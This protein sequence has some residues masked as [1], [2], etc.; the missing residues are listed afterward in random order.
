M[1]TSILFITALLGGCASL[2]DPASTPLSTGGGGMSAATAGATGAAG[3][4]SNPPTTFG[5]NSNQGGSVGVT[6]GGAAGNGSGGSSGAAGAGGTGAATAGSAGQASGG[7]SGCGIASGTEL[8]EDFESGALDAAK[9]K[10]VKPTVSASVMVDDTRPHRGKYALH[11]TVMPGQ[12]ST[13]QIADAVTFPAAS[14]AF[15]TRAYFYFSPDL[16]ADNMGGYHMAFLLATGNN[17]LGFVEAGL[18]SVGNKQYLGYSEY[19]GAGPDVH[20]HG[21]TFTEFGGS[22]KVQVVPMKWICLELFQGGDATTT[23]RRVWVDG[24]ELPEQKSLYSGRKPPTFSRM[25]IGV[26]QYHATPILNDVWVDDIRVSKDPIGC[27]K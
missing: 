9:W 10:S 7:S 13:A 4:I 17:D 24:M 27:D 25:S 19:Y 6:L 26:L 11:I 22:S 2:D 14:N 1:R 5:G 15:Y 8:C 21:P 3:T 18:A 12:S 20:Q 16:P 23:T